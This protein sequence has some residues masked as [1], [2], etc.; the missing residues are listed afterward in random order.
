[1]SARLNILL[2]GMFDLDNYG[3]L[4]F[5]L[6]AQWRLGGFGY[7]TI[8]V[9]PSARRPAIGDAL[10]PLDIRQMLL[11]EEP[12]VGILV[13]GGYLIHAS[14]LDFMERYQ[15]DG[16]GAWSG[17]GLWLGATLAGALRDVPIAWNAPGVPHPFSSR[18]HPLIDMALRAT[19]YAS[20]RDRGS[21]KLLG[22]PTDVNVRVVPDPVAD[23]AR[24]WP[25][26]SLKATYQQ[27]LRRKGVPADA[28]VLAIHV[29]NRSMRGL[30]PAALGAMLK[31]F[32]AQHGLVPALV[33]VGASHDDPGTA[34]LLAPHLGP[35]ALLLDDPASLKEI[36]SVF[37]HG[38]LYVGASLH[39]YI[40]S[41][42]YDT[43]GVLIARPAYQKFSGFLEHS[44]R[45]QDLAHDWPDALRLA[46]QRAREAAAAR[47]APA[48]FAA[49][50]AHWQSIH[51]AFAA[52]ARMRDARRDFALALLRFGIDSEG[53]GWALRSFPTR[54]MRAPH[55]HSPAPNHQPKETPDG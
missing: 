14:S 25:K 12:I 40:V 6:V 52:P 13:G 11:D 33:A 53:P 42:A 51:E 22:P 46:A 10:A 34:R 20:V 27:L 26:Q 49:L 5:P 47:I 9:A 4:L 7:E 8:P 1:M 2:S 48:V 21:A 35:S 39:G 44:G 54:A 50:D 16:A 24:L 28:R 30:E 36:T 55:P 37:A 45:L 41:A 17:V 31:T 32:A 43:P 15:T 29:R 3:D 23:I 19:G 18:Q 38:A